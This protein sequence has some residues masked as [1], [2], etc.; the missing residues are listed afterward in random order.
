MPHPLGATW[1]GKGVNFALFSQHATGVELCLFDAS[2]R[3]TRIPVPTQSLYVW[4]VY[5]PGLRPGQRYGWRVHGP[6]APSDGH[7]FNANKLLVDPYAQALD[8]F[9][10]VGAPIYGYPR[11]RRS[12]DVVLDERDDAAGKPKGVVLDGSFDW[13]DDRPPR[14][15]WRDTVLYELHVKGFTQRHPAV[16]PELRGT[17]LGLSSDAALAHL[18]S[19]G[20]TT[21]ELMPVHERVDEPILVER[22]LSNYWGYNTLSYFAPDRRFAVAK[23]DASREF[24]QMVKR[25]H[26]RGI[27]VV[28][29]VVY[30]HTCEGGA[31]GP[32]ISFRGIDN[33]VYYRLDPRDRREYIDYSGCGNTLDATHPQVLK[34]ITDSLRYWVTEM[35][36]D[37]FRFDLAPAL[38]R[39]NDGDVD[40][41]GGFFAVIHQDPFLSQIKLIAEPWDLGAGGYQVGSFPILWTEWN[42]RYRDTVRRFWRGERGVVAD[43]G[44][45]LTGSS[46]LFG[47]DGRR[48][49]ASINFVTAHDGFT[50]RDLVSYEE[51]HNAAN[52]EGNRDGLDDN[53]SQNCGVEGETSDPRVLARRRTL[54]R[55]IMTTLFVSQG[56]PMLEMGDEMWRTQRG[57]NNPYCHDS[58]LTWVDWRLDDEAHAMFDV[59]RALVA[60]RRRHA[61]LRRRDFLHGERTGSS[62]AKDIVW[63][64]PDGAEMVATDWEDPKRATLAFRLDG[65]AFADE[66]NDGRADA[67]FLVLLNG[68]REET[69]F[70]VP[71]AS[72]GEVWRIAIDTR[73]RPSVGDLVRSGQAV[74]LSAGSLVVLTSEV[75]P[76]IGPPPV[77]L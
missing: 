60:F 2:G 32:T 1:D 35:H 61:V 65:E 52:G 45:R 63:F 50:L 73:D 15:A 74:E 44:Y 56:V 4:H 57:N 39:G 31:L 8:G 24:K 14:V 34:L 21:V 47:D 9:L 38:A 66:R 7:R 54:A 72:Y 18:Q 11:D 42:G 20:V 27:E 25:L 49:H 19:L 55:S 62:P 40:R 51:K 22:G 16:A 23:G 46:D 10:D 3:E 37:G 29:D 59:T 33:R 28:I 70:D 26:A 53:A 41:V 58:E 76:S 77:A 75:A 6:F 30:N 43:M 48:P 68:E 71:P 64:R 36:V 69:L 5:V 12:I 13:E 67:S 17:F